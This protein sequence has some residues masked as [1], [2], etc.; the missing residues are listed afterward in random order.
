[1][2]HSHAE[3]KN[4]QLVVQCINDI[5]EMLSGPRYSRLKPRLI[6]PLATIANQ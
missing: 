2:K 3:T 1:M 6:Q 4:W 5:D